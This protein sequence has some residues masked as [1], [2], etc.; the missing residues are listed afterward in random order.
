MQMPA[1]T[2]QRRTVLQPIHFTET[3]PEREGEPFASVAHDARNVVAAL[4]LYSDLLAEPGVLG[5]KHRHFASDLQT[6]VATSSGLVQRLATLGGQE[7]AVPRTKNCESCV[8]VDDLG[9]F[10]ERL[11][12]L[13]ATLAGRNIVL[14]MECLPVSGSIRLSKEE[15]VRILINL[16]RN[17]AEAMPNGGRIRITVQKG[18][19][20]SFFDFLDERTNSI[21]H[22]ALLCMQDSGPGIPEKQLG[23]IFEAGF[24]T[25]KMGDIPRG[26]GLHIVRN[27]VEDAGGFVRASSPSGRGA[28]IEVELPLIGYAGALHGFHADFPERTNI[29]C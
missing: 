16:T 21:S 24:T 25:K 9:A 3:M 18:G 27:L 11:K 12:G 15:L 29:E 23:R 28:R 1:R 14:E 22:T 19:G 4:Q 10:V 6:I 17:A 20:G 5:E 2:Q 26:H 7:L 13:L 8:E